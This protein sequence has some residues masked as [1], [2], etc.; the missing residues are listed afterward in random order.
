MALTQTNKCLHLIISS[1]GTLSSL[2]LVR[3]ARSTWVAYINPFP[4]ICLC[5]GCLPS[6]CASSS[7]HRASVCGDR[8]QFPSCTWPWRL[9]SRSP[10]LHLALPPLPPPPQRLHSPGQNFLPASPAKFIAAFDSVHLSRALLRGKQF[11]EWRRRDRRKSRSRFM[12]FPR[13]ERDNASTE[14]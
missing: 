10:S 3:A 2:L 5:C 1:R 9:T 12:D 14:K 11:I 4:G 13:A 8:L 6:E 7:A